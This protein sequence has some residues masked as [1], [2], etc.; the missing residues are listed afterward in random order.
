MSWNSKS[1]RNPCSATETLTLGALLGVMLAL[2]LVCGAAAAGPPPPIGTWSEP[3]FGG[4]GGLSPPPL[5]PLLTGQTL[6][7]PVR[8]TPLGKPCID[9][10]GEAQAL[11]VN[12]RIFYHVVR[13]SNN[14][15]QRITLQVCYY[16]TDTCSNL[17]VPG[18]SRAEATLGIMPATPAFRFEYREQVDRRAGGL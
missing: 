9:L 12:K 1:M 14:C 6:G 17:Q 16:Q 5:P 7:P 18:Y 8:M 13:A 11:A 3:K 4:T 15:S 10:F 2:A